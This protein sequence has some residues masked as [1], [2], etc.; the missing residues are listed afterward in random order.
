MGKKTT[1]TSPC[2]EILGTAREGG[3]VLGTVHGIG[4]SFTSSLMGSTLRAV[5]IARGFA[6]I[7]LGDM[8]VASVNEAT[9]D[10]VL[11]VWRRW[12]AFDS[13]CF[14]FP[15][16]LESWEDALCFA[17]PGDAGIREI[18]RIDA[19]MAARDAA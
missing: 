15:D 19:E 4:D 3:S 17:C 1:K 8:F 14:T 12:G 2:N 5:V 16:D 18:R 13:C 7:Y 9:N 6:R 10:G 11:T